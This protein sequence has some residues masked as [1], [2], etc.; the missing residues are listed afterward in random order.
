MKTLFRTALLASAS[1]L[2]LTAVSANVVAKDV[3]ETQLQALEY[4]NIGPF[5]GGR[6]TAVAG[7][8]GNVET[9]YVGT[10]GGLMK[11]TNAG[12][13]WDI[14]SDGFMKT[15]S[16]G[17]IAVA[18]SDPNVV[19]VGMG[20]SPFRGVASAH[21]DG[22]YISTDAGKTFEHKGLED[23]RQIS[24]VHIDP[25]NPDIIYV[26]AQ[27]SP[28]APTKERGIY[29]ST[30]GGDTWEKTLFVDENS[31][32]IDLSVDPL[33]PRILYASMWDT[34]RKPWEVRSGGKGSGLW[35]SVDSGETWTKLDGGL[36]EFLGKIGIVASPVQKDRVW[37]IVEAKEKPG[38]YRSDDGGKN[39]RLMNDERKLYARSWY[40]MHIF[41]DT[42]DADTVYVQNSA[43]FKSIDGGK[44]FDTR[45]TGTHGDFHDLWINP[46]NP[47]VM[48]VAN[49]GGGAVTFNGGLTWSTQMNQPTA[50]FY[51]VNADNNFFYRVYAGQQD[52]STVG[53]LS[54]GPDGGIGAEDF[55]PVGGC[56]S[57]HVAFDPNNP[58]LIYAGCYLGQIDEF[59]IDTNSTRDVRVYP[60]LGF[61]VSPR[62]KDRKYRFNWNAPILVSKHDPSVIYHAGNH[63]FRS[64]NRGNSWD[65]LGKDL[66]KN[67]PE[68]LGPGGRPI[69]N[70]VSENYGTILA[71]AE[72]HNNADILWAGS[73]DGLVHVTRDGGQNWTDITPK[74]AGEG[75]VNS[76]ELS[77]FDEDTAYVVFAKY[78]YND[79]TP[80]IYKT[81]NGGKSYKNIAKGLPDDAFVRVVRED[82][83]RKGLLYAGTELGMFISFNDGADWQKFQLNLP[84]VPITDI[85]VHGN[86]LVL[87]TQGRAFWIMDDISPLRAISA[88][89]G[90]SV[91]LHAPSTAYDVQY[92]GRASGP[93][94]DNPP[95]GAVLYYTLPEDF[96][97][98]NET[99]TI[100]ILEGDTVV[101]KLE[102]KKEKKAKGGGSGTSYKLPAMSGLNKA[103]WDLNTNPGVGIKG[104]WGFGWGRDGK[105]SG[106]RV[107]PGDYTVRL[108]VG[109]TVTTQPLTVEFDPRQ[110]VPASAWAE[111]KAV[112][113]D[114]KSLYTEI[115]TSIDKSSD[116][117]N[118][119][120]AR[121][122]QLKGDDELSQKADD[123]EK[124]VKAW[125]DKLFS[126]ERTFFQDVLNYPDKLVAKI[127]MLT[128]VV[129]GLTPPVTQG[130]K[131]RLADLKVQW[132]EAKAERDQLLVSE[133]DAF[134][135]MFRD[136]SADT[137]VVKSTN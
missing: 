58:K 120:K 38:L 82:P 135:Q 86:D 87:S 98:E 85:K 19:V 53:I 119:I 43:F 128:S 56:E 27:G 130:A 35:K 83:N 12:Q 90:T 115:V 95:S 131:D 39:W 52:N 29:K 6:A 42:Q 81:T 22:V 121:K 9:Y 46:E 126:S 111:K 24:T 3:P 136:K 49:D 72:S 133:V 103:V 18:K 30:D 64:N 23:V 20:E 93:Q 45:I 88:D 102:S 47:S 44:T 77:T 99:I 51:R 123:L 15:A 11:T 116:L 71:L 66:S 55:I 31:G 108:T 34:Q 97:S 132:N 17:A 10:V 129:N 48:G 4:R 109:E 26:A 137:L 25:N 94:A 68:T 78:K 28:W 40:Y 36:P 73:D 63:V 16:V 124:A 89:S 84:I 104:Q 80:L 65:I 75:M 105:A 101:R 114:I 127:S 37:A 67:D 1:S 5:R 59:D 61:G 107:I 74:G 69:T 96:D 122:E 125:Q 62:D 76:I 7:V 134:N 54:R 60:E 92:Y 2:L 70:E 100:E 32:A 79:H 117:L 33:N 110:D 13:S 21:G 50:Q 8:P 112:M 91:E 14:I 57:G 113:A 106:T 41:A 118:Q